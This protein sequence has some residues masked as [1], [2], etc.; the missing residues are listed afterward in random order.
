[1]TTFYQSNF[2]IS[3]GIFTTITNGPTSIT[4]ASWAYG[5]PTLYDTGMGAS[6]LP[7]PGDSSQYIYTRNPTNSN[8]VGTGNDVLTSI[9]TTTNIT[10]SGN[11]ILTFNNFGNSENGFDY[12]TVWY[13]YNNGLN[14]TK[15]TGTN[16]GVPNF[17]SAI[18]N[19]S[20][21]RIYGNAAWNLLT[22][23][24]AN[25]TSATTLKIRFE[26]Q[27]DGSLPRGGHAISSV[28]VEQV[29]T[30]PPALSM[31]F[32]E[33][34]T[35]GSS[36][37]TLSSGGN[38][39]VVGPN[40]GSIIDDPTRGAGNFVKLSSDGVTDNPSVSALFGTRTIESMR[41]DGTGETALKVTFS[42]YSSLSSTVV[43]EFS[44]DGG[45]SW[46]FSS[47]QLP[48]TSGTWNTGNITQVI[49]GEDNIKFRFRAQTDNT[50][51]G[52]G[53]GV[54]SIT[55]EF[56]PSAANNAVITKG[57]V[58]QNKE[59]LQF[60]MVWGYNNT[61]NEP[62]TIY[63]SGWFMKRFVIVVDTSPNS[64]NLNVTGNYTSNSS[65]TIGGTDVMTSAIRTMT[66]QS[67]G[68]LVNI[69]FDQDVSGSVLD[70][71]YI[72]DGDV[73]NFNFSGY[74]LNWGSSSINR[75]DDIL[76]YPITAAQIQYSSQIESGVKTQTF[77]GSTFNVTK[78]PALGSLTTL[79]VNSA[80]TSFNI[81]GTWGGEEITTIPGFA[82][83]D[84]TRCEVV[85]DSPITGGLS[86]ANT[87]NTFVIDTINVLK[88]GNVTGHDFGASLILTQTEGSP[89]VNT[90][91]NINSSFNITLVNTGLGVLVG[92]KIDQI[93]LT[94][95]DDQITPSTYIQTFSRID[96]PVSMNLSVTQQA[97][98][99]VPPA[100]VPNLYDQ[101][102]INQFNRLVL[103]YASATSNSN[104]ENGGSVISSGT[105]LHISGIDMVT[106]VNKNSSEMSAL[107]SNTWQFIPSILGVT[108]YFKFSLSV[109]MNVGTPDNYVIQIRHSPYGVGDVILEIPSG[110]GN[111]SSIFEYLGSVGG[112]GFRPYLVKQA[113]EA[114]PTTFSQ[115]SIT[116]E[117][118]V[119]EIV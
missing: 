79:S 11:W 45:S 117:E 92:K 41:I 104:P 88:A 105:S 55:A 114:T 3:Q 50:S 66:V 71:P 22:T 94:Y 2:S 69:I 116:I 32:T 85:F 96:Q 75:F 5:S 36:N 118:I 44:L 24:V 30:L 6:G 9:E 48:Q 23:E 81:V 80:G 14:W 16:F 73:I 107:G 53:F 18:G 77:L 13:S 91:C 84:L 90:K 33:V 4:S 100:R 12:L 61:T 102:L 113:S 76:T 109:K 108:H 68:T 8:I 65:L 19:S 21:G 15:I 39:F 97:P 20:D 119:G 60:S 93:I 26:F 29:V 10:I 37:W 25:P 98:P 62:T 35:S 47:S 1:M 99:F 67:V 64:L 111:S 27:S 57:E 103:V 54:D 49:S 95:K 46:P 38:G 82:E 87:G 28:K 89:F 43:I 106:S 110:T 42:Y 31:P 83:Y 17:D 74:S 101:K 86:M 51:S 70:S 40:L 34:W 56:V 78:A 72:Q 7:S 63:E 52:I 115:A 59:N 112:I 58:Q